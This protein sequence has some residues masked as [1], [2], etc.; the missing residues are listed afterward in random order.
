ML[1]SVSPVQ[2]SFHISNTAPQNK[3]RR[4]ISFSGE[5]EPPPQ[6]KGQGEES[7][8]AETVEPELLQLLGKKEVERQNQIH[9]L[10][11]GEA[12]YVRDI[13]LL[14]TVRVQIFFHRRDSH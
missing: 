1:P 7:A 6:V 14:R 3:L 2:P 4:Q 5:A 10:I 11:T 9:E 13:E 8:W 12:T